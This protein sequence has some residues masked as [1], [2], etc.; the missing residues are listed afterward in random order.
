MESL[1]KQEHEL[2]ETFLRN[3]KNGER[4][5][6]KREPAEVKKQHLADFIRSVR[7]KDG[8]DYKP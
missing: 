1:E 5:V 2:L 7:R 4:E 8:E 6:Q 3:E